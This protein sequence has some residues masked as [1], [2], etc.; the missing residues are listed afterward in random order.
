[1]TKNSV[2]IFLILLIFCQV[3]NTL[4]VKTVFYA[5][6]HYIAQNLCV[7]RD[8]PSMH[9]NGK[10]QLDRKLQEENSKENQNTEHKIGIE[11]N[12]VFLHPTTL[13]TH[14]NPEETLTPLYGVYKGL[15]AQSYFAKITH[16]P[17]V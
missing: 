2:N 7:N 6:Q 1:M 13:L 11:F 17:S 5:N 9:C 10:C 8:N 4:L 12:I 16:P 14:Y 3:F 15:Y